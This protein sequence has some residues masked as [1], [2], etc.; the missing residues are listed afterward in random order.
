[1]VVGITRQ[2]TKASSKLVKDH[3]PLVPSPKCLQD[4]RGLQDT[5]GTG[6]DSPVDSKCPDSLAIARKACAVAGLGHPSSTGS[7]PVGATSTA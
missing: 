4:C 1:M 3:A 6:E 2:L 5:G 7:N